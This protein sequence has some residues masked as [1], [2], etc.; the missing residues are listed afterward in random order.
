MS[1]FWN[2]WSEEVY[3]AG[4][5]VLVGTMVLARDMEGKPMLKCRSL[6]AQPRS[7]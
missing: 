6:L 4:G 3:F 2:V 1:N 7:R 5:L